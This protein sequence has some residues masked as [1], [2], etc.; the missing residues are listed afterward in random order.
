M[1]GRAC[2]E[3]RGWHSCR[4]L[5]V[6]TC[7]VVGCVVALAGWLAP[8]ARGEPSTF[9]KATVGKFKEALAADRKRVNKYALPT[10]GV[11]SHL[12]VYLEASS[13][14]GEQAIEGVLYADARV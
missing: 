13:V 3:M 2:T 14:S 12:S 8:L 6:R 5:G 4:P 7:V 10:V 9:G 11:V 1:H